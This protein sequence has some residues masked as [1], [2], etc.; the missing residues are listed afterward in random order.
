MYTKID[1]G[2]ELVREI[3]KN[4]NI[5]KLSQWAHNKYLDHG[6]FLDDETYRA[7]MVIISM[8]E[9]DEFVLSKEEL[10]KM[11]VDLQK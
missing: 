1:F 9:G 3:N 5:E 4:F 11:A 8:T 6:R 10:L 7:M 2:K